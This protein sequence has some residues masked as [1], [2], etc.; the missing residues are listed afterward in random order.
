[1]VHGK[2]RVDGHRL[3]DVAFEEPLDGHHPV[4]RI[5]FPPDA[6]LRFPFGQYVREAGLDND[7]DLLFLVGEN[8]GAGIVPAAFL[9]ILDRVRGLIPAD[10]GV[11]LSRWYF[12][13]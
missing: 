2:A 12:L 5:C 13:A 9:N 10:G 7:Q 11:F 3:E 4:F 8:R 6:D 1:M